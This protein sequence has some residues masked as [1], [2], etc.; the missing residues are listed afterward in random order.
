MAKI[1][2][3][4]IHHV[5]K[6]AKVSTATVSRASIAFPRPARCWRSAS[7]KPSTS[8]AT[9]SNSQARALASE[10]SRIFGL[11]VSELPNP[12][13]PE[14]VQFFE[15]RITTLGEALSNQWIGRCCIHRLSWQRLPVTYDWQLDCSWLSHPRP[16]VSAARTNNVARVAK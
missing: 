14:I 8:S 15:N 11:V 5:A 13:F 7:G 1:K 2:K 10:G 12:F 4:D 9:I 3:L 16:T 6:R